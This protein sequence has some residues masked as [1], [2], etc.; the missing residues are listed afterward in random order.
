MDNVLYFDPFS[1]LS[2]DMIVGALIDLGAPV[3]T[4][5]QAVRQMHVPSLQ[6]SA[7]RELR[8]GI[9]A[10]RFVVEWDYG[11]HHH[12]HL[13][14]IL[15]E[16]EQTDL[17][18]GIKQRAAHAF[19]YLAEAEAHVHGSQPDTVHLHEVGAEDSIA[20]VVAACAAYD[21]LNV[22]PC[23]V[24]PINLGGGWAR[25]AHGWIPVPGPAT[26]ALLEPYCV[27]QEDAP[28]E[29][30]TPTGAA[31]MRAFDA[32]AVTGWPKL[33]NF[34]VGYGCGAREWER[35]NVLR[36]VLGELCPAGDPR[37]LFTDVEHEP[38]HHAPTA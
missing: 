4:V 17:S 38:G 11:Q 23:L 24:G 10:T 31:L 28:G 7:R 8:S 19:R 13:A 25:G 34:R 26:A 1:G 12:R 15:A 27:Y 29:L 22:P 18:E 36:A 14:D 37:P 30:T 33:R 16:L 21:A 35:P 6:V 32:K 5:E 20:D 3:E 2:G 9:R